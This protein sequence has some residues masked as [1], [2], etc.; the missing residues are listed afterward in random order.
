V[1]VLSLQARISYPG[2]T[3]DVHHELRLD[4]IVGLFGA[5]GSGK[6]TLLRLIAGFERASVGRIAFDGECWQDTGSRKFVPAYRR[7]AGLVFQDTRLFLHRNVAGNLDFAYRRR[8]SRAAAIEFS[9]ILSAFDLQPL[10][11]RSVGDLSGGERQ[12]VAMARTLLAQPRV[13]LLDEPL[14]ALDAGRKNEIIPYL[15]ALPERFGIPVIYVSH[16][17]D[18]VARLC[19]HVIVLEGGRIGA[20]GRAADVL[21]QLDLSS[22]TPGTG[23]L[24]VIEAEVVEQLGTLQLTRLKHSA[25]TFV[26]PMLTHLRPGAKIRLSVRANDVAIATVAPQGLSFRNILS[27]TLVAIDSHPDSAF[28][29]VSVD[30][31]D[32]ILKAQL[33][34]HAVGELKLKEGMAVFALLKTASFDRRL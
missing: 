33:T 25:H 28:A 23:D 19:D 32:T 4:R 8:N 30:I 27:G 9:E 5:S 6:S 24:T 13:L 20:T 34:R 3:L 2:F 31:G 17:I 18:E 14:A 12:R 21:N 26:V 29:T 10:L 1:P 22:T 16:A 11:S 7:P 15:E